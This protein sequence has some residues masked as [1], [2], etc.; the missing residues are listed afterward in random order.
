MLNSKKEHSPI[1]HQVKRLLVGT[2]AQARQIKRH[3][4]KA[5]FLL[6]SLFDI[7]TPKHAH[8]FLLN[9]KN[10]KIIYNQNKK[11]L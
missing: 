5:V 7:Q 8:I 6:L 9:T 11:N 4:K 1:K 2:K 10:K 3:H